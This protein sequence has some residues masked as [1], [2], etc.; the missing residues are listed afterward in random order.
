MSNIEERVKKIIVE[1]LGVD[2]AEV[3]N[4][5]SFVDD[6]GADSLDTVELVMAL[7]EEFDT[8]IPDEEAEKITTVQAAIDYVVGASE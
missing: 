7:E 5:A 3:K 8:E 6:L 1:Q 4:E 2:E